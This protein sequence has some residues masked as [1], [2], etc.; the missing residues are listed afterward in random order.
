MNKLRKHA[1]RRGFILSCDHRACHGPIRPGQRY[2]LDEATR[3]AFC[4][5]RCAK[6]EDQAM[7]AQG[8]PRFD[9]AATA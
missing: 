9:Q 5:A 4:T 3:Q 8:L 7:Q 1:N 6:A 2:Y